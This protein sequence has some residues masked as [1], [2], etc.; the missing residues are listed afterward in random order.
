MM[1]LF[2]NRIDLAKRVSLWPGVQVVPPGIAITADHSPEAQRWKDVPPRQFHIPS[3]LQAP[4]KAVAV[5]PE[6]EEPEEGVAL[7]VETDGTEEATRDKAVLAVAEGAA[8]TDDNVVSEVPV[9]AELPTEEPPE[10]P[11]VGAA[12]ATAVELGDPRSGATAGAELAGAA[13]L[14][15]SEEDEPPPI[16][17]QLVPIGFA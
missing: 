5:E 12:L 17:K 9:P 6:G 3:V 4:V 11:P 14:D 10:E 2:A 16:G 8:T 15:P 13:G 7:G 1:F